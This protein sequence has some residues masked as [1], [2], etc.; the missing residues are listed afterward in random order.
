MTKKI[1]VLPGDGIGP[2]VVA[3]AVK[4]L[5]RLRRDSG[6]KIE[7]ETAPVGG[8][9]YDAHKHPLPD[10]TLKLARR[11]DAVLL[12]AVGGTRWDTLPRELRPEKALLG[13]RSELKLFAN[14]RP[15]ILYPQLASASTLKPEIVAGLDLLIVRELT[16]D[17]YFGEPRGVRTLENGERQGFNTMVYAEHEVERVARVAFDAARKRRKKLCSVEKANVLE[18]SGLW[19]EVVV[20]VAKDYPDIELSHMYVDNAAMQLVRAPKQFDVIVTGNIF[21]DIL[22]DEAAMLTGSIGMLPSASL[23]AANKGMYE[24]IHGSAPDIAGKGIANPLATI[25]SAAMMLRYT[26]NEPALA[27]IVERAVSRVLD[28]GLRTGDIHTEGTKKVG[29]A[30][31]GDA[32]V[33]AL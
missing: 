4:V 31:M 27:G 5:E 10:A 12:G 33:K 2:E 28:Q 18:T 6:L 11:A 25:L 1:A 30:E 24:P 15:A 22:S 17:I 23:D 8:T 32:V 14:L 26:L 9:A 16:G 29:T 21:G 13:L 7:M 19:R 3:E 20:R